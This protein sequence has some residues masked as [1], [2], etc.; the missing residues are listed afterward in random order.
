MT[1]IEYDFI[2]CYRGKTRGIL[3]HEIDNMI[4]HYK[5]Q[6]DNNIYCVIC[7]EDEYKLNLDTC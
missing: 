1:G 4:K 2:V 7:F 6:L 5:R 3:I